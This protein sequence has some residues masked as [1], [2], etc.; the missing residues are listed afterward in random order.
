MATDDTT[1]PVDQAMAKI[2]GLIDSVDRLQHKRRT[3]RLIGF[4]LVV[5]LILFLGNVFYTDH[6]RCLQDQNQK[7]LWLGIE[8]LPKSPDQPP[9][10]PRQLAAFNILLSQAYG[11]GDCSWAHTVHLSLSMGVQHG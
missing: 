6:S 3:D 10:D 4:S 5:L 2:D 11:S 8:N 1:D 7:K 9:A